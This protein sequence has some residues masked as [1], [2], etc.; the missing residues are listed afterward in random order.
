[1][2]VAVIVG[3]L[4]FASV[5]VAAPLLMPSAVAARIEL[6]ARVFGGGR[7][8]ER[9]AGVWWRARW[10]L[11]PRVLP[12]V[13]GLAGVP[14]VLLLADD[15]VQRAALLLLAAAAAVFGPRL[16]VANLAERRRQV[17]ADGLPDAIDLLVICAE[18]GLSVDV[19]LA[20][21]ARELAPAAPALAG[22]LALAATE[23]G[24]L[25]R[26]A[27]AFANLAARVALPQVQTLADMMVQTERFGTPLAQALR[28]MAAEYRTG[29]LL[30]AEARAARLPALMTVPMIAFILPPLFVVLI[31]PAVV[32]AMG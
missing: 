25:P 28:T 21:T 22:E 7:P 9:R 16:Y 11:R 31:G 24:L 20:R 23:L 13:L 6:R 2:P 10:L 32:E 30:R 14:I 3:G 12:V 5:W 19:A 26:R 18:A 29:R 8:A 1:M 27:D 17:I 15:P 4:V